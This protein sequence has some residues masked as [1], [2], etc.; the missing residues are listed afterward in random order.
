MQRI[1]FVFLLIIPFS[2]MAQPYIDVAGISYQHSPDAAFFGNTKNVLKTGYFYCFLNA[3]LNLN[4]KNVLLVSP[5]F[6]RTNLELN[7][8]KSTG[9][10]LYGAMLGLSYIKTWKN[11]KWKTILVSVNRISSDFKNITIKHYQPGVALLVTYDRNPKVKYKL[12]AYYNSEFFGAFVLPLL[13]LD[14]KIT[15]RLIFFG[16]LP[17]SMALEYK[18]NKWFYA[19]INWKAI[20]NTYRFQSTN[21]NDYFKLEESQVR[22]FTDIY[23]TKHIVLNLEAGHSFLR[24][25]HL[26]SESQRLSGNPAE[27]DVNEGLLLKAGLYYR[28]RLDDLK[29]EPASK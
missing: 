17:R 1:L 2:L 13:G 24:S 15:D 26:R 5:L 8:K 18:F 23:F 25:Y 10:N 6:E 3:P 7:D 27:L 28:F 19:G 11:E 21:A 12:G 9:L 4:K 22:L 16:M 20:T 14:W 29:K